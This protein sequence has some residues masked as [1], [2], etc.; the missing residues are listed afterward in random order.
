MILILKCLKKLEM[1][2]LSNKGQNN[3][4]VSCLYCDKLYDDTNLV[5]LIIH[6]GGNCLPKGDKRK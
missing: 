4:R 1:E 2:K 3:Q 6:T 5:S